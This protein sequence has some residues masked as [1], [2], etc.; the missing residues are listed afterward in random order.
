MLLSRTPRGHVVIPMRNGGA[1][2][3][4][5]VGL[6]VLVQD[7]ERE[8]QALPSTTVGLLGTYALPSGGSDQLAYFQ[9]N[10]PKYRNGLVVLDGKRRWYGWDYVHFGKRPKP[11]K[12]KL[13]LWYTDGAR[14]KLRWTCTTYSQKESTPYGRQYTVGQQIY[15]SKDFPAEADNVSP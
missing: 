10:G 12:Q 4:L 14:R 1:G 7:C 8:P 13:L 15:G 11:A 2:I 3:A 5:T 9:P 6:P